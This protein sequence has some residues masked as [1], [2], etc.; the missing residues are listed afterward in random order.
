[1]TD[2]VVALGILILV[3]VP[4]VFNIQH[5]HRLLRAYYTDAIAMEIVD[6]ELEALVA[7]EW[8]SFKPGAQDYPVQ[9]AAA[10]NL[11]PGR[12]VLTLETNRVRLEWSPGNAHQ[13][14]RVVREARLK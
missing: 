5:E 11:P 3:M 7:G 12:F 6:G 10:A 2:A 8:R 4:L 1:M 13:G 9:A 14:A